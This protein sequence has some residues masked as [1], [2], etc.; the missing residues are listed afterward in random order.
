[1][2]TLPN[3]PWHPL[4]PPEVARIL[5]TRL[6]QGLDPTE[7]AQR[8]ATFG[9]N[10]L[11]PARG[12][13]GWQRFLLQFHHPL[14]YL[15]LAAA[16]IKLL[17]GGLTDAAVIL[18]VVLAN[19][20]IGYL[21]EAKA[22]RAI[23]A[24]SRSLV[25]ETTVLRAGQTQ[26]IASTEL[27]PGDIVL[28]SSGDKVPAD[29]R[30]FASRDL[31]VAEAALTG[32][33]LPIEKQPDQRLTEE[34][35]LADRVTMAYAS[36]LVT[37][38]QGRGMVV[39][40][41]DNT[42]IG[43]ISKMIS[44]ATD[45]QTPLTRRMAE[46]GRKL[47]FLI[48]GLSGLV[49]VVGLLR[50]ESAEAIAASAIA[51]AVGAIPEGVPAAITVTL[52]LGVARMAKRQAIIRQLPAVETLGSTT[53]I[54]TDKTG[55]LT[56]N[57]MTVTR[58]V[59]GEDLFD[60]DGTG[61]D[62]E[63]RITRQG[64]IVPLKDAPGL[65]EC[66]N[67]GALCNDSHLKQQEGRWQA[68]GDPTE[69]SLLVAARKAGLVSEE[70]ALRWPRLDAIPFESQHQFMA[71]LHHDPTTGRR[72]IYLKGAVEV[73]VDRCSAA[74]DSRGQPC[75]LER[76]SITRHVAALASGGLRVLAFAR[77]EVPTDT[78]RIEIRTLPVNFTFL[79]LQ[80]MIDP[81]R[82]EAITSVAACHQAGIQV[83]MI[84]GDHAGTAV[85]IGRQLGLV[86]ESGDPSAPG[87]LTGR[88][89]AE[90]S[91]QQLIDA[92]ERVSVFARVTPE[93]KLRLVEALQ[94]R[95][96][97]VAMTG[98]G[99]NDGP[100]LKQ[101]NIGV[102]MGI[103]GTE[104]AKEAS[105]MVLT[106]DNF[107]SIAAAVEEGR[108]VYDNL[109]KV[110]AWAL[111]S[112]LGQGLIILVAALIGTTLPVLPIQ[113][114]W[115][116]MT[117]GGVLGLFLALE[118]RERDLMSRPPR[119]VD[120]PL[121]DRRLLAQ[122]TLVGGLILLAA[123]GLFRWELARGAGLDAARTVALNTVAVVQSFY[124]LNCRSLRRSIA[125]LGMFTNPKLLA[126]I[127]GAL[128]LQL[129]ITYVPV[130]NTVFKTA[131]IGA[132][133]WLRIFAAGLCAM[134]AVEVFKAATAPSKARS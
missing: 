65:I 47:L 54:C 60:V 28:L 11:T 117:T 63:G 106:D 94:S 49:V 103:T 70:I 3:Q 93:Q 33:S 66:L 83:K 125:S 88:Q 81:P 114:L 1:M 90:L 58:V 53:V 128:V 27:V 46:F 29:L 87:A 51:L 22:E 78:A 20:W 9:A 91:N 36:T 129:A 23:E 77:A 98:D 59:I 127:V 134:A 80:G 6:D 40:T 86:T 15:L 41:G 55:T 50:G 104:V 61:Y 115:L 5:E 102:A 42:E 89:L 111:P 64:E 38:G 82:P 118:P 8:R 109:T 75:P 62:P 57:Q 123:F 71:S 34:T 76:T 52:A 30:L 120:A 68:Q 108:N 14:V 119:A 37:Q 43:R 107:A 130:L 21:Q 10:Q 79:G 4:P 126:G 17:M 97:V 95:N 116:N 7:V 12:L 56:Q 35:P 74:G 69:V 122:V 84:T 85:A 110:V 32:E 96:H 19:A 133:E 44:G 31:Q 24:L 26:R 99:V 73:V 92:A 113:V 45:L 67:A 16:G 132:D 124:L 39:G 100:A 48:L 25:M 105:D 112:N 2:R 101:A 131:P 18:G 13:A 121:L 72:W